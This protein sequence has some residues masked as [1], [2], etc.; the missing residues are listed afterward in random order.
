MRENKGHKSNDTIKLKNHKFPL[1]TLAS[2]LAAFTIGVTATS[3]SGGNEEKGVTYNLLWNLKVEKV[4]Y[5]DEHYI[6]LIED[7]S[8]YPY[9]K[10]YTTI[11]KYNKDGTISDKPLKVLALTD[12]HLDRYD[13]CTYSYSMMV[14]NIMEVKPDFIVMGGDNVCG[15]MD[16]DRAKQF[17][18]TLEDLGV[19][20]CA[21]LGNHEGGEKRLGRQEMVEL[22]DSYPH[23]LI[24]S[25]TKITSNFENVWGAGNS[26]VNVLNSKGKVGQVFYFLDSGTQMTKEDMEE[27]KPEIDQYINDRK[28]NPDETTFYDYIKDSQI[29]WYKET[30]TDI[31][32]ESNDAPKSTVISHV[33]LKDMEDAYVQ[34]FKDVR[35][36][37]QDDKDVKSWGSEEDHPSQTISKE[38]VEKYKKDVTRLW[39]YTDFP[40]AQTIKLNS[41]SNGMLEGKYM[42]R[43]EDMCYGPHDYRYAYYNKETKTFNHTPMFEAM[44][45]FGEGQNFF[46]GHDHHNN[47]ILK[48]DGIN[49]G[50]LESGTYSTTNMWTKGMLGRDPKNTEE[51]SFGDFL[52]QGYAILNYDLENN[53]KLESYQYITN[54][55]KWG[56][57]LH[58]E[59]IDFIAKQQAEKGKTYVPYHYEYD[60]NSD[61]TWAK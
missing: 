23:C 41:T 52:Q 43:R 28:A 46:C 49:L 3:C 33:P 47:F 51:Y 26:I 50:Y 56:K 2:V 58:S 42:R 54:Y 45:S 31:I 30:F 38:Y 17:C 16:F 34:Y 37:H 10:K 39:P 48:I 24:D 20:W 61:P 12:L 53:K 59:A 13:P 4:K 25:K 36:N 18:N 15:Y 22:F 7:E 19:Y 32:G 5:E 8:V 9:A 35:E 21:C 29:T 44:K 57:D 11:A 60:P 40:Q 14:K 1:W 27:Y 55:E 6:K